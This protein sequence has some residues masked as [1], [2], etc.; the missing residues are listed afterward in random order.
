MLSI[1]ILFRNNTLEPRAVSYFILNQRCILVTRETALK[2]FRMLPIKCGITLPKMKT[3]KKTFRLFGTS[4]SILV[5][6]S[7]Y[8]YGTIWLTK[9]LKRQTNSGNVIIKRKPVS[10]GGYGLE[11]RWENHFCV[12]G[13]KESWHKKNLNLINNTKRPHEL[14]KVRKLE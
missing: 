10:S 5:Y 8:P 11:I 14:K 7:C 3:K 6:F 1:F 9:F 13:W 4:G 2:R 12:R